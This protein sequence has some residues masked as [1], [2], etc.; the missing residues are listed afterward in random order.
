MNNSL[1]MG[2]GGILAVIIYALYR[3][4]ARQAVEA[5]MEKTQD[6]D[7]SLQQQ[8]LENQQKLA[9]VNKDLAALYAERKTARDQYLTDQE[10]ASSWNQPQ[11]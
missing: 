2:G 6:E 8:Q 7:K 9:Q 4:G 5:I 3:W 1:L 11:K 10:K